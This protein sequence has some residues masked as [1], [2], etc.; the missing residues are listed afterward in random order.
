MLFGD[1]GC[2]K[3]TL[4]AHIARQLAERGIRLWCIGA[5]PGTPAFGPPGAVSLA[6]WDAGDWCVRAI[7]PLCTLDA[8]RFRLPVVQ[9]IRGLL[10]SME[11]GPLILDMPGVARGVAGAELLTALAA[12]L[13]PDAVAVLCGPEAPVPLAAE[14]QTL[15]C[16][17]GRISPAAA[18]V[19]PDASTR[20]NTRTLSWDSYLRHTE[21]IEIAHAGLHW[22]GMVPPVSAIDAWRGRQ[23][24]LYRAQTLLGMGEVVEMR[25]RTVVV[26][27]DSV[28]RSA[29]TILVRDARRRGDGL[30][31]TAVTPTSTSTVRIVPSRDAD[32]ERRAGHRPIIF[33]AGPFTLTLVNGVFGDPLVLVR[34]RG[35]RRIILLDLG[36]S[37]TLSRRLLH[38]V[39]DVFVSHAHFD[40]IAGFLWLLRARM[41]TVVPACRLFGPPGLHR[42]VA[43]LVDG[44]RW[45]RIGAAGPEFIVGEVDGNTLDRTRIKAGAAPV[46]LGETSLSDGLLI[47]EPDLS[48]RAV[49]LEHGIPVLAFVIESS[50]ERRIDRSRLAAAGLFPGPWLSELKRRLASGALT[51]EI[52]LPD[53]RASTV[54]ALADALVTDVPSV[55]LVYATDLADTHDN[56]ARLATHARNADVLL[57]EAPF[58]AEDA[59]QALRTRHLTARA[60]GEIAAAARVKRLVPFHFSK[61]YDDR[62]GAVYAEVMAAASG[63]PVH[64][65]TT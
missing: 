51:T 15:G 3:S 61:R 52:A 36:E 37:A 50:G 49:A 47:D 33:D 17:L 48:V 16:A 44:V 7:A 40:H 21:T 6:V 54:A 5:D 13:S 62:P 26:R 34:A 63:V 55:R 59:G 11:A 31:A 27:A 29:D 18:A 39:T 4:A 8:G 14:L 23:I 20:A 2:G 42:H 32:A 30:L 56:R 22:L 53:G 57:C 10:P 1:R 45:D 24:A 35:A 64:A 58:I 12:E 38:R 43:G 41:G 46:R 25:D 19:R 28:A 60:C 65:F 9:A